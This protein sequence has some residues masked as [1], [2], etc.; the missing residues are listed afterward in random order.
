MV[1]ATRP[2]LTDEQALA[3][4]RD[5]IARALE[6]AERENLTDN[7]WKIAPNAYAIPSGSEVDRVYF[8][9]F[10]A[11]GVIPNHAFSCNCQAGLNGV[12]CKH[13]AVALVMHRRIDPDGTI[14]GR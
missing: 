8:V 9:V 14:R 10:K 2:P 12:M 1:V 7:G 3:K 11:G 13:G 4:L 6:R 5:N